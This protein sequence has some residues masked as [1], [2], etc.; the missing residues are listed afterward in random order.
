MA[1]VHAPQSQTKLPPNSSL[2]DL[3]LGESRFS[4]LH[5]ISAIVAVVVGVLHI[6]QTQGTTAIQITRE[7]G[8]RNG[9]RKYN[10]EKVMGYP[11]QIAVSAFSALSN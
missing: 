8:Y 3:V 7:L 1:S 6:R 4:P 2:H 11:I 10:I 5:S 9:Q